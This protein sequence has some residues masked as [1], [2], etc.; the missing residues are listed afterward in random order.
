MINIL[1]GENQEIEYVRNKESALQALLLHNFSKGEVFVVGFIRD[2]GIKDFMVAIGIEEGRGPEKYKIIADQGVIVVTSVFSEMPDVVSVAMNEIY[3]ARDTDG[4]LYFIGRKQDEDSAVFDKRKI[5]EKCVII[6]ASQN[7][8]FICNPPS[9]RSIYDI[10]T[11]PFIEKIGE[12]DEGNVKVNVRDGERVYEDCYFMTKDQQEILAEATR[13]GMFEK[14]LTTELKE[15]QYDVNGKV[16]KTKDPCEVYRIRFTLTVEFRGEKVRLDEIPEGWELDPIGEV[17]YKD[18]YTNR[19]TWS[20]DVVCL[21]DERKKIVK[22]IFSDVYQYMFIVYGNGPIK[23]D[24][25][26]RFGHDYL[27]ESPIGNYTLYPDNGD[28]IWF[29]I[30]DTEAPYIHQLDLKYVVDEVL[31]I[32]QDE[33]GNRDV[34]WKN[35]NL[36]RFLVYR[37]KHPSNGEKQTLMIS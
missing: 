21:Y 7:N 29:I 35:V 2:T 9:I 8:I 24:T 10:M 25:I 34:W 5:V 26:L 3:V 19:T 22:G 33:D 28:Y 27:S 6:S 32:E 11:S 36:G 31:E 4:E 15:T 16:V 13:E 37:S 17:Y 1:D 18:V 30:Q 14:Y 23:A 12:D 20:G